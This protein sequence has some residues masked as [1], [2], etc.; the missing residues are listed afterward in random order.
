MIQTHT[1]K[2]IAPE[3]PITICAIDP[4]K[5]TTS[6]AVVRRQ[7][8]GE[9]LNLRGVGTVKNPMD[10]A[11]ALAARPW[12]GADFIHH[13]VVE[14]PTAADFGRPNVAQVVE[15]CRTAA[16][17]L[18]LLIVEFRAGATFF[19][20]NDLR[21]GGQII[22]SKERKLWFE[23]LYRYEGKTNEHQRDSALIA[24]ATLGYLK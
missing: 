20:A 4:G 12:S 9:P 24:A 13:F 16:E 11:A 18:R 23:R 6:F 2:V 10:I 17:I 21:V 1:V 22:P 15:T 8:A 14:F 5:T 7:A 19:T 3:P